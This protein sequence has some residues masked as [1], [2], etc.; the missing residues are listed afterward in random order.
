M[1]MN[2]YIHSIE[3]EL[4][5]LEKYTNNVHEEKEDNIIYGLHI[6]VENDQK[7]E[8]GN[9]K[10]YETPWYICIKHGLNE[11]C[12]MS[13]EMNI[14]HAFNILD[15][16]ETQTLILYILRKDMK[17]DKVEYIHR[18]ELNIKDKNYY[19]KN[20][21]IY[22]ENNTIKGKIKLYLKNG[23][24]YNHLLNKIK[25]DEYYKD[26]IL[27]KEMQDKNEGEL[28][29]ENCSE[30]FMEKPSQDDN[31]FSRNKNITNDF[32]EILNARKTLYWVY[33]DDDNNE[34]G[35]FN[36]QTIFNWILNEY[37]E[38]N[39]LIRL[40]DK[41]KFYNLYE[42]IDCIEK[43]VLLNTQNGGVSNKDV[44]EQI[45]EN[46]KD[47]DYEKDCEQVDENCSKKSPKNEYIEE[48][49]RCIEDCNDMQIK[50][51]NNGAKCINDEKKE[52]NNDK[53]KKSVKKK[54]KQV[55]V[56]KRELKKI[57][58]EMIKLKK[59]NLNEKYTME[60]YD[61]NKKKEKNKSYEMLKNEKIYEKGKMIFRQNNDIVKNEYE[62]KENNKKNDDYNDENE[63][64]DIQTMVQSLL[65]NTNYNNYEK[66]CDKNDNFEKYLKEYEKS[67]NNF[68][69]KNVENIEKPFNDYN[70]QDYYEKKKGIE[71][72]M[73]S[74]N[75]AQECILNI[76]KKKVYSYLNR[77]INLTIRD[78]SIYINNDETKLNYSEYLNFENN[79]QNFN[80][81]SNA[82]YVK[83]LDKYKP[84]MITQNNN[85][86]ENCI[87]RYSGKNH[88]TNF[89]IKS[90]NKFE[91][92]S[93][94]NSKNCM[95][96]IG[97]IG[98]K[99]KDN[100]DEING[101]KKN[102]S[103][104][105]KVEETTTMCFNISGNNS[106]VKYSYNMSYGELL[107]KI[108]FI[109]SNIK[110]WLKKRKEWKMYNL[111]KYVNE[112]LDKIKNVNNSIHNDIYHKKMNYEQHNVKIDKNKIKNCLIFNN[113]RNKNS[114]CEFKTAIDTYKP[115]YNVS[116][117]KKQGKNNKIDH[118]INSKVYSILQKEN[119]IP[120]EFI[121]IDNIRSSNKKEEDSRFC[122]LRNA[123]YIFKKIQDINKYYITET[124][125]S[126]NENINSPLNKYENKRQEK[127]E[128]KTF[129]KREHDETVNEVYN[130][131]SDNVNIDSN[132][133]NIN[134]SMDLLKFSD[135][136]NKYKNYYING[137]H[138]NEN[139]DN[140]K[141]YKNFVNNLN[142][143]NYTKDRENIDIG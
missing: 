60:N 79:P 74:I 138:M 131:K 109:Q 58:E 49:E 32:N 33:L 119:I 66:D 135:V 22:F 91:D 125:N 142:K 71:I 53:N 21:C 13:Y 3:V 14:S 7:K 110:N 23:I 9:E 118:E 124:S 40:H 38:D 95:S 19:D 67:S 104:K 92:H 98:F 123:D 64:S 54:S 122:K 39:T 140:F 57:K 86:N 18:H 70:I 137:N 52:D 30:N 47:D 61:E 2:L 136:L 116:D 94:G 81:Q 20:N 112:N 121:N 128:Q 42:I 26:I 87:L 46:V 139:I 107:K 62:N 77:I 113:Y 132:Q 78:Q 29:D 75:Q 127:E 10:I 134:K 44:D 12:M 31:D 27:K 59:N 85:E 100:I 6:K 96:K 50:E 65:N 101:N 103:N 24:I 88:G 90:I 5:E 97:N 117:R 106:D 72:V 80:I 25:S 108:L 93:I 37:F 17:T 82:N 111:N 129:L 130:I 84:T 36:S 126:Y 133:T 8:I 83:C 1:D 56:L 11:M 99:S 105:S 89:Y 55:K 51:N 48:K 69:K 63:N 141:N 143:Y 120:N 102:K 15:C 41:K 35:P 115:Y 4:N 76:R 43:N 34:Q 45:V 68:Y 114:H 28:K 73:S 16:N